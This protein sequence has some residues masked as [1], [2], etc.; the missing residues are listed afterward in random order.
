MKKIFHGI[1]T[2]VFAA[3]LSFAAAASDIDDVKS[4]TQKIIDDTIVKIFNEEH[5]TEESRIVPFRRALSDNFNFDHIANFVLG[6]YARGLEAAEKKSFIDA[7]SELNV[8]GY[9]KKFASYSDQKVEVTGASAAKKAGEFFV[10]SRVA[11][12]ASGEK[13]IEVAWRMQK[14]GDSYRVIDVVIEGVSMAMSFKNEYAPILKAAADGGK[15]PVAEL[16]AKLS[17]KTAELKSGK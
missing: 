15:A 5:K 14:Y 10:E 17:A 9:A 6:V 4:Y 1:A 11:A 16:T 13:D 12:A 2:F 7:F 8:Y 3:A